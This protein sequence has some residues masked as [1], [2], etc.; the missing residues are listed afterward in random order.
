MTRQPGMTIANMIG[1]IVMLIF[2]N[3]GCKHKPIIEPEPPIS[4]P[5]S[6][7]TVFFERDIL[8]ILISNCALS[9][10]HSDT[11]PK[12]GVDLTSYNRVMTTADI[13]P[14]KAAGDLW[15]AINETK[16][17]KIMPP[18][19]RAPLTVEQKERIR[20]WML[21][22]AKN[23]ICEDETNC[24]TTDMSFNNDI[25][26]ILQN[27]CIGCHGSVN[28]GGG[29]ILSNFSGVSVVVNNNK[30]LGSIRRESGFSPMPKG[31]ASLPQCSID[32]ITAW[33]A[34]GAKDN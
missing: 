33:V 23:Y 26:P 4:I 17:D 21:Q 15:K 22:G 3:T 14:G 2:L 18:P 16:P 28:P 12:E 32:K 24:I 11:N 1:A 30:L 19:P 8:P 10:C 5:C 29:F 34:Q 7:D 31:G 9:G 25:R 13:Q 20:L 27:Y 6:P